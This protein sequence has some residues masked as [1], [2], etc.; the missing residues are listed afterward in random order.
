MGLPTAIIYLVAM[1]LFVPFPFMS[2]FN[3][4]ATLV[5][6]EQPIA[7]V[8]PY[9]KVG[10][11]YYVSSYRDHAVNNFIIQLSEILSAL[12]AIQ[13][14]ALLGFADDVFD[15]RWRYKVWFPAIAAIPLLIV[16]YTNFGVTWVMVPLQLR[17]YVGELVDLGKSINCKDCILTCG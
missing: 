11:L 16:Y 5:H 2:F 1:F 12:L 7:G 6:D 9:H 17:P 3:G 10:A 15:V 8:F 13:S 4:N 14:M